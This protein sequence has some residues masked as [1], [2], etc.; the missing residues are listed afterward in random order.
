M[1]TLSASGMMSVALFLKKT[2]YSKLVLN[3]QYN[4]TRYCRRRDPLRCAAP[5]AAPPPYPRRLTRLSAAPD[6]TPVK[7]FE[8]WLPRAARQSAPMDNV[9][10][11]ATC[12]ICLSQ[13]GHT[14]QRLVVTRCGH[15]FHESC[16]LR[17][18]VNQQ[19]CPVCRQV[20][21]NSYV[22]PFYFGGSAPSAPNAGEASGTG[23]MNDPIVLGGSG[24]N[25]ATATGNVQDT[26]G[27]EEVARGIE[28]RHLGSSYS[29]T[30]Y[31]VFCIQAQQQEEVRLK[32]RR[33]ENERAKGEL[34]REEV[35]AMRG[36]DINFDEEMARRL[37]VESDQVEDAE[38]AEPSCAAAGPCP[39]ATA[40][41][42]DC[43]SADAEKAE[44]SCAAAG[45]CPTAT[46]TS[47]GCASAGV[48]ASISTEAEPVAP[49]PAVMASESSERGCIREDE[50]TVDEV[51]I[52]SSISSNGDTTPD[53]IELP[54]TTVLL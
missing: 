28:V 31:S 30:I 38:E 50:D 47:P 11:L 34:Y 2:K 36:H 45:P 26:L 21:P 23:A 20:C 9:P 49:H 12:P 52:G 32:R 15:P 16:L 14:L 24:S 1:F 19:R 51:E 18:L 33:T 17:S 10:H 8:S 13:M 27:D 40:T 4:V 46:A 53:E 35:A 29:V 22:I 39:T 54:E 5:F 7:S 25:A 3:F 44:P 37:E 42:P 6:D 41:S 48:G 43:A